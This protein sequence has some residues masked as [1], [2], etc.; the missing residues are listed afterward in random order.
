MELF[1][2]TYVITNMKIG[3]KIT[4]MKMQPFKWMIRK[5]EGLMKYRDIALGYWS[6]IYDLF[7]RHSIFREDW[8][9]CIILDA[10]RYDIFKKVNTINGK[11]DKILSVAPHTIPFC[12]RTF[13][14]KKYDDIV[15]LS[16]NPHVDREIGEKF[17]DCIPVWDKKEYI[18]HG[19]TLPEA[20]ID[21]VR[22]A[23][24]KYPNKRLLIW[25]VQP[26]SP[27]I[28][29]PYPPTFG[30]LYGM[31]PTQ[32]LK[33]Y[34]IFFW[35]HLSNKQLRKRYVI[36]LLLALGVIKYLLKVLHGTTVITSD[37]GESLG[38]RIPF[39]PI[40]IYGHYE[41]IYTLKMLEVPYLIIKKD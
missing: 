19:T 35:A 39:T 10:C 36:N 20:F 2:L 17:H 23:T 41:D 28:G 8:D 29:Y 33:Q 4:N 5:Q 34:K 9:N 32:F 24:I 15:C 22:N 6:K 40:K 16:A 1:K 13:T 31:R 21:S 3:M 11:L 30:M 26:H 18:A 37:H 14:K 25:F 38:D 7:P 27:Y 12:H